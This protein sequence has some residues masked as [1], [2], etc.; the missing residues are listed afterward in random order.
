M[1]WCNGS[2]ICEKAWLIVRDYVPE[3]K[4]VQILA[5]LIDVFSNEDADCWGEVMKDIPEYFDALKKI[6]LYD[7]YFGEDDD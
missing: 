6:D 5:K 2:H 7:S 1:G 3:D 4:R